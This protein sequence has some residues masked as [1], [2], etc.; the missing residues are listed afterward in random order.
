MYRPAAGEQDD[1]I[2]SEETSDTSMYGM[3]L[4]QESL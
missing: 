3:N 4:L 2:I 1:Y